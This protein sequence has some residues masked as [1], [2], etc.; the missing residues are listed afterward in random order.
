MRSRIFAMLLLFGG[1]A[2]T[3]TV[4][5]CFY[6]HH[7]E[8]EYVEGQ[9]TVTEEPYYEQWEHETNKEHR[10]YNQRSS[11]DQKAYWDWRKNHHDNDNH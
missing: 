6:G 2:A 7:H 3:T 10:D 5:G 4:G 1:V 9:W 11:D 8:H